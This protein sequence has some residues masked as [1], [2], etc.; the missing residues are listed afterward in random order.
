M[1][2]SKLLTVGMLF[3]FA[4]VNTDGQAKADNASNRL[5]RRQTSANGEAGAI[6]QD[7]QD[8]QRGRSLPV[9]IYM[10][11]TGTAPYP[12]VIFS[13][14]LGGTRDAATYLGEYW[15]HHGYLCVFIQ[16]P[17]SDSS[18]WIG[19]GAN[20]RQSAVAALKPAANARNSIDRVNDVKFTI[21]ELEKRNQSDPLLKGNAD[22]SHI[23][24]SGH[25]F[26]AGTSLYIA[27]Q[28]A[29]IRNINPRDER[30]KA[31]I[32]L[33]PPVSRAQPPEEAY[34]SIQIPGLTLTGTNDNSP[35]GDTAAA[36][37]RKPFDAIKSPH[38]YL[39]TFDG[40]DHG[41]F[42]GGKMRVNSPQN[43]LFYEQVDKLTTEFLDAYLK[44][45]A[46]AQ[47][48]LDSEA[49]TYLGKSAKF[50]NK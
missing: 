37:R 48:W 18:V 46:D 25:S 23:A 35:I 40:A 24:V 5:G 50:E 26:G 21:D 33:C 42:A 17:G 49:S 10:P 19:S 20:N 34:G 44:G 31:A 4:T 43:Q 8:A 9:K 32:Y 45:D 14:G 7:W 28:T 30:V 6:Y 3:C 22:L 39:V 13:H 11:T 1:K 15:S 29:R 41:I 2:V 36:D 38:Q 16:H 27:G 12:I 47:R